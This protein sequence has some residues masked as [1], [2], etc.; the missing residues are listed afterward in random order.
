M[1][2]R[3]IKEIDKNK[4]PISI[5]YGNSKYWGSTYDEYQETAP[6]IAIFVKGLTPHN[7]WDTINHELYHYHLFKIKREDKAYWTMKQEHWVI[8]VLLYMDDDWL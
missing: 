7:F 6:Y 2:T 3:H 8:D 1:R 4:C 5:V